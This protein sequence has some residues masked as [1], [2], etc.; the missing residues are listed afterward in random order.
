MKPVR[1]PSEDGNGIPSN[2]PSTFG[3]NTCMTDDEWYHKLRN[4]YKMAMSIKAKKE[5][6][7]YTRK[8]F[9]NPESKFYNPDAWSRLIGK[10]NVVNTYIDG[11]EVKTLLHTGAQISFM[12]EEYAKK[13][14]FKIHT[15][16]VS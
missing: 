8:Q 12:S 13:R 1:K 15:L 7:N 3:R 2:Q 9:A 10:C 5:R 14:G 11:H 4:R 6:D 16:E